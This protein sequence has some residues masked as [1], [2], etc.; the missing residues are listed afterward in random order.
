MKETRTVWKC[1]NLWFICIEAKVTKLANV[2]MCLWYSRLSISRLHVYRLKQ[3]LENM[4][5]FIQMGTSLRAELSVGCSVEVVDIMLHTQINYIF[6]VIV[7]YWQCLTDKLTSYSI[8]LS[9]LSALP[10]LWRRQGSES[11]CNIESSRVLTARTTESCWKWALRP[12]RTDKQILHAEEELK[13]AMFQ[14]KET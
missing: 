9:L 10:Q 12:E 5:W 14:Q 2:I 1:F 13:L 6:L 3:H 8:S 4:M 11:W 7:Y